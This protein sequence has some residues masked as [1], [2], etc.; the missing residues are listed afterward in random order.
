MLDIIF[1][2]FFSSLA[3]L[4]SVH[5][6]TFDAKESGSSFSFGSRLRRKKGRKAASEC[7]RYA[8]SRE[9]WRSEAKEFHGINF[10]FY[11]D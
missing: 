7:V 8:T 9:R 10:H 2:F 5:H 1:M 3:F 11:Y 6:L 4:S